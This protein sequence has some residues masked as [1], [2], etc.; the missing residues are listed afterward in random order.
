MNARLHGRIKT[1]LFSMTTCLSMGLG[2]T[3][4]AQDTADA[5]RPAKSE[6]AGQVTRQDS[7]AA[8]AKAPA[9]APGSKIRQTA[10]WQL[11]RRSPAPT[12][13]GQGSGSSVQQEL[14]ELYRKNGREMPNMNL[15]E[16]E[17]QGANPRNAPPGRHAP[18]MI[19][20]SNAPRIEPAKPNFLQRLFGKPAPR[21]NA[22]VRPPQ[23]PHQQYPSPAR[24]NPG[25]PTSQFQPNRS[26]QSLPAGQA[27]QTPAM[28]QYPTPVNPARP[29]VAAAR[30]QPTLPSSARTPSGNIGRPA[31]PSLDLPN[32]DRGALAD[33]ENLHD[34]D[35]LSPRAAQAPA[36]VPNRTARRPAESPYSGLTIMPGEK[37]SIAAPLP[38]KQAIDDGLGIESSTRAPG[39]ILSLPGGEP[40]ARPVP[41]D[42]SEGP[43]LPLNS[44][45]NS[46]DND[47]EG[48]KLDEETSDRRQPQE[49][50]EI[51][52]DEMPARKASSPTLSAQPTEIV[53]GTESPLYA[54]PEPSPVSNPAPTAELREKWIPVRDSDDSEIVVT[55]AAR[56]EFRGFRGFCPVTLRDERK[57]VTVDFKF[58]S[59]YRG[60]IYTFST[61]EAKDAFEENPDRYLPAKSGADVVRVA[62]GEDEAEGSI[63]HAAW[64]RGRLYLFSS[65]T[66]REEFFAAPGQFMSQD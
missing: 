62:A 25:M 59:E 36:I 43:T 22:N 53:P 29:P 30:P 8:H 41:S 18:N 20:G 58:K 32:L 34:L 1:C 39:R 4:F 12:S 9:P 50:L 10:G 65:P 61:Q 35:G 24:P 45:R 49:S 19:S 14:Q 44:G 5:V 27:P 6:P 13:G 55:R 51:I 60:R 31:L 57:L 26:A 15:S 66:S 42:E 46:G 17:V 2:E 38:S 63:E 16:M 21:Q 37:E 3:A 7:N 56:A 33:E 11:P 52:L 28:Q 64:Y 54:Q 47:L 40:Q 23:Q 48:L